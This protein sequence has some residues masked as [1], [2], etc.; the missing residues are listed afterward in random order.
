MDYPAPS[1][2]NAPIQRRPTI[3]ETLE[4]IYNRIESIYKSISKRI[5]FIYESISS[6]YTIFLVLPIFVLKWIFKIDVVNVIFPQGNIM[7]P[8]CACGALVGVIA[9]VG[10]ALGV[11]LGVGLNCGQTRYL[12]NPNA[13]NFTANNSSF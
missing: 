8:V 3:C 1:R 12:P 4:K 13:T 5:K 6:A 10:I 2:R 7:C 11:G 9:S